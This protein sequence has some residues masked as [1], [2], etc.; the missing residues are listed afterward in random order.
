VKDLLGVIVA[1]GAGTRMAGLGDTPKALLPIGGRPLLQRQLEAMADA[2]IPEVLIATGHGAQRLEAELPTLTPPGLGVRLSR[3][4][5]PAGSGGCLAHACAEVDRTLLVLFGDVVMHMDLGALVA[6]HRSRPAQATAVVHPNDHPY[7]SD[8]VQLDPRGRVLALHRKPHPDG[9][10]VRNLV[11]A[12]AFVL[13]PGI[14]ATIPTDRPQDLVHDILHGALDL[15]V[16]GYTTSEYLKDMGTPRRYAQVE[17]DWQSGRVQG[18]H[19]SQPRAT[20]FLDRDG[21]LNEHVGLVYAPA[22]LR[23]IPGAAPAVRLL[24]QAGV[25]VVL[26]TNQ[27]VLAR[28][29]CDA[30][31][32][33]GIHAQLER[34]LA[35]EGAYLD[36]I[37][38]CPHHPD[39]GFEGEVPSLKIPCTCRKPGVGLIHA[40][41]ATQAFDP[42]DSA[43]FGDTWRDLE[44]ARTAGLPCHVV[45]AAQG[46]DPDDP[47]PRHR[48]LLHG[49][50]AWLATRPGAQT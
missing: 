47:A 31:E 6:F 1:G 3:D 28:G 42:Q 22:Q 10:R 2:G 37:Q 45:G 33:E 32:L 18:S 39:G 49:V 27:P 7:D 41:E 11:T 19:R 36:E 46:I 25:R 29:L 48:D 44:M 30:T 40:A 20:A 43:V 35:A 12:G 14:I 15:G 23:L 38:A 4:P 8:L 9:L 16:Y 21:T 5:F 24:N 13:E 50:R 17:Q 34:L 26:T